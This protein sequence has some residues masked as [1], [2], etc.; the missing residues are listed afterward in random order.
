M[1]GNRRS[2]PAPEVIIA[3]VTVAVALL[4]ALLEV[5]GGQ[6]AFAAVILVLALLASAVLVE[7][8]YILQRIE[9]SLRDMREQM[10]LP[11]VDAFYRDRH[12]LERLQPL[13]TFLAEAEQ[14]I[15]VVGACLGDV[16]TQQMGLLVQK[17][18]EDC[19]KVRLLMMTPGDEGQPPPLIT[20]ASSLFGSPGIEDII[21]WNL[22]HVRIAKEPL[23]PETAARIIVKLH[24]EL[25]TLNLIFV[26]ARLPTGKILVE[27]LPYRF[28]GTKRPS[29]VLTP[30]AGGRL[31]SRLREKYDELWEDAANPPDEAQP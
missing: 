16:I 18:A 20:A 27:L 28:D 2:W 30:Q 15:F 31:Y 9:T 17:A 29:F 5:T 26:D 22:K 14:D 1:T 3:A 21:H 4:V 11:V 24:D 13:K 8:L 6:R 7:R 23:P 19:C 12:T 10:G 25:P